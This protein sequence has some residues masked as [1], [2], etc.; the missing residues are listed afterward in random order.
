[1]SRMFFDKLIHK[2][3]FA[4]SNEPNNVHLAANSFCINKGN[5][6]LTYTGQTDIDG[7]DRVMDS[8]VDVGADE[9][10]P[11]CN[12]VYNEYD[13]NADGVIN[14]YEFEA[15]SR[16]WLSRD[17]ADP[18][19][20]DPNETRNWNPRCNFNL[21]GASQYRIDLADLIAF[22]S[23]I[24]WGWVACWRL[25][26]QPEQLEM[27]MSMA[28]VGGMQM[29]PLLSSSTLTTS[30]V[31]IEKPINEQII[32]LKDTIQFLERLWLNDPTIQQEIDAGEWQQFIRKVQD[33]V[34][35]L[36]TM[37]TKTLDVS[38]ESQ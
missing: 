11:E 15:L 36:K 29:Q 9:V 33:S 2:P 37:N 6:G 10:N 3:D 27:M 20:T 35:E 19:A 18:G 12:D 31:I 7:E 32:E 13:W 17:P 30:V 26:L 14:L 16:A 38:E 8:I 22:A 25:E 5:P 28:P 21:I 24:H 23:N 1:M 4:Y 34:N